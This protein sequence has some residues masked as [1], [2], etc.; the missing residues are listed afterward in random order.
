MVYSGYRFVVGASKNGLPIAI[1]NRGPTR[2]DS[3]ATIRIDAGLAT[4]WPGLVDD[5][6]GP[7]ETGR[8]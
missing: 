8:P 6:L 2:G 5:V 7:Q 3:Q 4:V 1:I